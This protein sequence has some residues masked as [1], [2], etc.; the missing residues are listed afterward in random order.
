M[1]LS[2]APPGESVEDLRRQLE[3]ARSTLRAIRATGF[4]DGAIGTGTDEE[5]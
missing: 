4:D 5:V 2:C 1:T 3:E